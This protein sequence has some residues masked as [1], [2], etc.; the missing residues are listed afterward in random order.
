LFDLPSN[1]PAPTTPSRSI[2]NSCAKSASKYFGVSE[3]VIKA[4]ARVEGG[5]IGTMSRNSNGTYDMGI[6][7]INTIHLPDI[8]RKYPSI[9]WR[10][11]A[12]QPCVN[13]GIGAWILSQ[14]LKETTNYWKGVGNYHSKTPKYR[15]RYLKKVYEAY[16]KELSISRN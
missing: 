3:I 13:I 1:L 8:A 11:V 16:K 2:I 15:S 6:M 10:E 9:G 7:Q 4:L 14:R 5:K 12:Y